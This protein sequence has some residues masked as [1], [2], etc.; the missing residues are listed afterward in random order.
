MKFKVNKEHFATGLRQVA[1]VVSSKPPMAV[2]NNVLIKAEDGR[3]NKARAARG[4]A[5]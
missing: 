1:N 2:L 5:N 3:T 4:R